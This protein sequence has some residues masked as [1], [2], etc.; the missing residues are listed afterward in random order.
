MLYYISLFLA[1]GLDI[2]TLFVRVLDV[3][4]NAPQFLDFNTNV[5]ESSL[6]NT[7]WDDYFYLF[8]AVA[9]AD[10]ESVGTRILTVLVSSLSS[11]IIVIIITNVIIQSHL[12]RHSELKIHA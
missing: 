7:Y 3:N 10:D 5:G 1:M 9:V 2:L 12:K 11:I 8:H 6:Y 4:D